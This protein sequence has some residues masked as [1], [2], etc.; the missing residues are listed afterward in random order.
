MLGSPNW[1]DRFV[2]QKTLVAIG[3]EATQPLQE[4]ARDES[5]PLQKM[6]IWL[7][8]C[9]EQETANRFAWRIDHTLCP[10]CLTRFEP[11]Q[12]EVSVGVAFTCYGC[13]VCGQSREYL[14]LPRGV[15]AILDTSTNNVLAQKKGRLRVNW[16]A[17]RTLFDFDWV[18][19]AH[20]TDEDVERFAV[21]VGNDTDPVRQPR[22][23]QMQCIISPECHLS[24]NTLR[25][26]RHT[27]GQVNH[28]K[29]KQ[30]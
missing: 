28:T 3:G 1:E 29:N 8:S 18:G 17:K 6:G 5:N 30:A 10:H 24:E 16:A 22:Y 25:V 14:Y 23:R 19:I 2:A 4:I 13:R 20:A 21:Q 27:F 12:I 26:L 11:Q 9:I 15:V 7:L